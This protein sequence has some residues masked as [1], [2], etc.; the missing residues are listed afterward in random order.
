RGRRP[1]AAAGLAAGHDG[2][3]GRRRD[4]SGPTAPRR[5]G[6]ANRRLPARGARR[7]AVLTHRPRGRRRRRRRAARNRPCG[8]G[9]GPARRIE[10]LRN[11]DMIEWLSSNTGMVMGFLGW[12]AVLSVTPLLLGLVIS[13]P[14][15]W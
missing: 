4:R 6:R 14:L 12:H 5:D 13:I 10:R 9:P 8:T 15:G 2:G 1:S 3:S 11:E 7:R